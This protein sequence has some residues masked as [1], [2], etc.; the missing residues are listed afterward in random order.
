MI[1]AKVILKTEPR[2]DSEVITRTELF[3]KVGDL[4]HYLSYNR[5]YILE[6]KLSGSLKTQN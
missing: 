1:I 6:L 3:E 2:E 4:E 5:A